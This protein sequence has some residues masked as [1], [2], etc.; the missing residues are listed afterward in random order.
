MKTNGLLARPPRRYNTSTPTVK[1]ADTNSRTLTGT[2]VPQIKN[3]LRGVVKDLTGARPH[4]IF[5]DQ[6]SPRS[7]INDNYCV[8]YVAGNLVC[9]HVTGKEMRTANCVTGNGNCACVSTK[10][11]DLV[12]ELTG[13]DCFVTSKKSYCKSCS[14][15]KWVSAKG[16][17]KSQLLLSVFRNKACEQCFL[18][19]SVEFC[20]IMSQMSQLLYQI[21]L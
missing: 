13:K 18:C 10:K 3:K 2:P 7:S 1:P 20:K 17:C 12:T 4:L 6:P 8:S 16:R 5:S 15:C 11:D 9:A 21:C 19:R 14:F